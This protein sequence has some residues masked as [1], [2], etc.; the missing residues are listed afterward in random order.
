MGEHP[1]LTVPVLLPHHP[2]FVIRDSVLTSVVP[3]V[4]LG[5]HPW[6]PQMSRRRMKIHYS[7]PN[8]GP[9]LLPGM[10]VGV[11][12]VL[13]ASSSLLHHHHH[14]R[15]KF[16]FPQNCSVGRMM[17]GRVGNRK[18]AGASRLWTGSV[19]A[20]TQGM[21]VVSLPCLFPGMMIIHSP[22]V[23]NGAV[24]RCPRQE[25]W[26]WDGN[27]NPKHWR[28]AAA[29]EVEDR[30]SLLLLLLSGWSGDSITPGIL[31]LKENPPQ[32]SLDESFPPLWCEG[33]VPGWMDGWRDGERK[34][35]R[36]EEESRTPS[37][38]LC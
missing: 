24:G 38:R 8:P 15:Q 34:C 16:A 31:Q 23:H 36:E 12:E 25:S 19:V 33:F 28:Q 30:P 26:I 37:L 7:V 29:A 2:I 3:V 6:T 13:S 14:Q 5:M 32:D 17:V 35:K 11:R 21:P 27:R 1:R 18:Q 9:E 10:V 4:G 22:G 20:G